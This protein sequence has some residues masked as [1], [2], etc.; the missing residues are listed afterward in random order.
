MS[1]ASGAR[2][3]LTP[4]AI[5]STP[6]VSSRCCAELIQAASSGPASNRSPPRP[7]G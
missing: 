2:S 4:F 6:T 1:P 7:P 5:S 3:A